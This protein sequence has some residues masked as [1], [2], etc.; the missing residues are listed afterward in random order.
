MAADHL[1]RLLVPNAPLHRRTEGDEPGGIDF[2]ARSEAIR[3]VIPGLQSPTLVS[4]YAGS[5]DRILFCFPADSA[6]DPRLVPGYTSVIQALRAGTRFV[7]VHNESARPT[8]EGWFA[9]AGHPAENLEFVPMPDWVSLTDW[10]EDGY[11]SLK[12]A[13]DDSGYLMEPWSFPRAGDSLIADAVE[14]Y[15]ELRASGAPLVF[16]GGNCLIGS[17]FWLLGTDYFADTLDLLAGSRPPVSMPPDADPEEFAQGLFSTYVD[18]ARRLI[19]VG[20]RRPIPLRDFVGAREGDDFYLDLPSEGAGTFQPIFHIDMFVTLV[21]PGAD[22]AFELLVGSPRLADERLGVSSPYAL[23]DV[24]D[25]IAAEF[26]Q[27][28]FAVT[29]NPLVHRPTLG[30]T[31]S[32]A[33]LKELASQP[34]NSALVPAVAELSAAGAEDTTQIQVRSWHHVTWNNCLVENSESVGKHVYLPTFGHGENDDLAPIDG[35]MADLW[36]SRGFSVHLLGDF[37]GFAER[38]GVVH[39]I[40]KYVTRGAAGQPAG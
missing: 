13:A 24:Y 33:R 34:A 17:D 30:T 1:F 40:K 2:A 6:S 21:G 31:L 35:D 14:E 3:T 25:T 29:R 26:T 18:A 4:T 20:T 36:E 11:V 9:D 15:T 5:I 16:Q 38:Q 12:D 39:C 23:D 28:G 10:A 22:G 27:L 19:L 32:L 7:I 37:N 8:V